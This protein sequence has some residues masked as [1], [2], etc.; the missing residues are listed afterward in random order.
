MSEILILI[1]IVLN[2]AGTV[3]WI[4]M[5]IDCATQ[6]VG[7]DKLMWVVIL[8]ATYWV[9]SMVYYFYQRPKRLALLQQ[10]LET[11]DL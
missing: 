11:E 3:F 6:E 5:L 8:V 9:G 2:I 7:Q 10:S 4:Y 1:F